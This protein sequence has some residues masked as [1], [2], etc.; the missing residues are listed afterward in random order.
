M[1]YQGILC[2]QMVDGLQERIIEEA[3]SCRY[4]IHIGYTNMYLNFREVYWW[5]IILKGIAEFI[6]KCPNS[7]QVK[8]ENQRP[9]GLAQNIDF[10]EWK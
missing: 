6:A 4:S 3:H 1:R 7:Q 10:L 5:N 2:V 9:N 8:I